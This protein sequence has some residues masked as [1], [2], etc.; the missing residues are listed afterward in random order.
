MDTNIKRKF[1]KEFADKEIDTDSWTAFAD[2]ENVT[3]ADVITD[4]ERKALQEM[5]SSSTSGLDAEDKLI[6]CAIF[7]IPLTYELLGAKFGMTKDGAKKL[8]D[9]TTQKLK[10]RCKK[11]GLSPK[12]YADKPRNRTDTGLDTAI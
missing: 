5:I 10:F 8:V 6:L 1:N 4:E 12:D 2:K 7:G 9:K 3:I 11:A